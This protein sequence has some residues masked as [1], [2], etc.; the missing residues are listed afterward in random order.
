M[1]ESFDEKLEILRKAG[2]SKKELAEEICDLVSWHPAEAA[3]FIYQK[4]KN[5]PDRTAAQENL[6]LT[7]DESLEKLEH[8]HVDEISNIED[9]MIE[10]LTTCW[11]ECVKGEDNSRPSPH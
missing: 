6:F 3:Y 7:L 1:I 10:N 11:Q 5:N 9:I 8:A 4:L 2:Y